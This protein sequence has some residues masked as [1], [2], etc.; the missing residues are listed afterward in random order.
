MRIYVG[1]DV[2]GRVEL[3]LVR[4]R[5]RNPAPRIHWGV[6]RRHQ[7]PPAAGRFTTT[8]TVTIT[9]T[10]TR[11]PIRIAVRSE[12]RGRARGPPL[13]GHRRRRIDRVGMRPSCGRAPGSSF[14]DTRELR[15]SS[16]FEKGPA[17]SEPK[18]ERRT[19]RSELHLALLGIRPALTY[20]PVARQYHRP[21]RLNGRVRN[22]IGC[23]PLGMDTGQRW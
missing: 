18:N 10:V 11:F 2:G 15:P 13:R 12:R 16:T 21:Q 9:T 6:P 23:A 4:W 5:S 17:C 7:L 8:T 3:P 22:G 20:F 14:A 19:R 1:C